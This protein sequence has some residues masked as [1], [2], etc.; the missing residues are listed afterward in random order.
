ML[1]ITV[2]SLMLR[3]LPSEGTGALSVPNSQCGRVRGIQ[4]RGA[5]ERRLSTQADV[6][7]LFSVRVLGL[8]ELAWTKRT[9]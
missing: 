7:S 8:V 6:V 1:T 3:D 9:V 5:R 4:R 2:G